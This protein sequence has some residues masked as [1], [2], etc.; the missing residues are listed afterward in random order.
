MREIR[1]DWRD[2]FHTFRIALDLRKLSLSLVGM[3]LS[4]LGIGVILFVSLLSYQ[5]RDGVL[6]TS[7]KSGQWVQA[8]QSL[9][10]H[11]EYLF[12][13]RGAATCGPEACCPDSRMSR[14]LAHCP[15][16]RLGRPTPAGWVACSLAALWLLF[17]WSFFGGAISRIAAVEIA[18]DERIPFQE[19]TR[20]AR[21]RYLSCL[22]APLSVGAAALLFAACIASGGWLCGALWNWYGLGKILLVVG[23]PL[24]LLGSFLILLLTIGILLGW[25]MMFPAV[26]AEGTDAFDAV[27]RAF[28]YVYSR[29]WR[30]L[31][32]NL[33]ATLYAI[34]SCL[35]VLWFARTLLNLALCLGQRWM[36]AEFAAVKGGLGPCFGGSYG[37]FP[38]LSGSPL[39]WICAVLVCGMAYV[40]LGLAWGYILSYC[41]S[42]RTMIYLLMRRAVD[43]TEMKEV[44]EEESEEDLVAG[45]APPAGEAPKP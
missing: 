15:I 31:W 4:V 34:P 1:G 32:C 9:T 23:F 29:P 8:R 21:S 26:A 30:Y 36:P 7:V 42:A 13:P 38:S 11:A 2:I 41:Y 6:W 14:A 20:F 19:A 35:F 22:W 45:S 40:L 44:F 33:V 10:I 39:L 25:P 12:T 43:G 5:R 37:D 3:A 28:S 24:A 16:S 17:V 18:R 27:T